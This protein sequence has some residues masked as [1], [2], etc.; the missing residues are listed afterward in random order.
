M[1]SHGYSRSH[2]SEPVVITGLSGAGPS[3]GAEVPLRIERDDVSHK[4]HTVPR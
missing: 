1:I 4:I 3:H 2:M